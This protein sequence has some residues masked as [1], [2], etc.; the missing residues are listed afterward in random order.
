MKHET[1]AYVRAC[2]RLTPTPAEV[3]AYAHSGANSILPHNQISRSCS[4]LYMCF[5]LRPSLPPPTSALALAF[6]LPDQLPCLLTYL[7]ARSFALAQRLPGSGVATEKP[8]QLS[9]LAG[10]EPC[11]P[12]PSPS[13][14]EIK[15]SSVRQCLM[16]CLF[17]QRRRRGGTATCGV[18]QAR[19]RAHH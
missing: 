19:G 16:T 3:H 12:H 7:L 9:A 17:G 15:D 2:R 14:P 13:E 5:S 11:L 8:G 4:V 6:S 10:F 18:Y 1:R